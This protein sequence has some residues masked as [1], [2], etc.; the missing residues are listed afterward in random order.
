MLRLV[1]TEVICPPFLKPACPKSTFDA[2]V[3]R[4]TQ[5]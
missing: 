1:I 3:F 4:L 5:I 2:Q